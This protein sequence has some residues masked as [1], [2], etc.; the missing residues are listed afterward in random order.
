MLSTNPL[1][2]YSV[3]KSFNFIVAVNSKIHR[4]PCLTELC[5]DRRQ[6]AHHRRRCTASAEFAGTLPRRSPTACAR[7]VV[8]CRPLDSRA[9]RPSAPKLRIGCRV[10]RCCGGGAGTRCTPTSQQATSSR[11]GPGRAGDFPHRIPTTQRGSY[12]QHGCKHNPVDCTHDTAANITRSTCH[13]AGC[14]IADRLVPLHLGAAA[15]VHADVT[16][17]LALVPGEPC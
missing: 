1:D 5:L 15:A 4:P 17:R 14:N 10:A 2:P 13:C 12:S 6:K 9:R 11:C 16:Q 3:A 8:R 7:W